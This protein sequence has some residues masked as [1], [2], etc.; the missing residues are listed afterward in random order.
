MGEVKAKT[1]RIGTAKICPFVEDSQCVDDCE[2][3]DGI[4]GCAIWRLVK[5]AE[6]VV[7]FFE[8]FQVAFK[9]VIQND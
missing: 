1:T 9:A 5:A 7:R 6:H 2:W 4:D 8:D 3:N